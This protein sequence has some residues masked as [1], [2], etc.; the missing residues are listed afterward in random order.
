MEQMGYSAEVASD[1]IKK[2]MKGVEQ[3]PTPLNEVVSGTQRL[4]SVTHDVDKASDWIMAISNAM[5][6]NGSSC[7]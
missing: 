2:L 3:V 6:S 1:T 7:R 5:L 4:V